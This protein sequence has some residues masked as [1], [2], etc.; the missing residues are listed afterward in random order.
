MADCS[1]TD[2]Q[3]V[4][5]H[6]TSN[7]N[8]RGASLPSLASHVLFAVAA[9]HLLPLAAH[10]LL[11][12]FFASLELQAIVVAQLQ[13][14]PVGACRPSP[15]TRLTVA[16]VSARTLTIE[17]AAAKRSAKGLDRYLNVT[18]PE[19]SASGRERESLTAGPSAAVQN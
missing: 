2:K 12:D 15:I 8:Q 10:L 9:L 17:E 3:E 11:A 5:R 18:T 6:Y 19:R 4:C 13:D 1:S 16:I 14:V 7:P